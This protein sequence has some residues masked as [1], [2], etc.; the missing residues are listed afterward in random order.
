MNPTL[1]VTLFELTP[2]FSPSLSRAL[3]GHVEDNPNMLCLLNSG[4][5]GLEEMA[6]QLMDSQ[7]HYALGN[8]YKCTY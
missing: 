8:P 3:F 7:M 2:D 1:K 6:D 4:P 5:G